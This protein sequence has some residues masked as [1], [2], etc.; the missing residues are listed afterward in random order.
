MALGVYVLNGKSFERRFAAPSKATTEAWYKRA[1][2]FIPELPKL[3][4][5]EWT[6]KEEQ[7]SIN[8]IRFDLVHTSGETSYLYIDRAVPA[9]G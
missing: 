1:R 7:V 6:I 9:I 4:E 8:A 2:A 5:T 3:G